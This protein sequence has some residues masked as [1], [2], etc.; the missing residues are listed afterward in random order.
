MRPQGGQ[1][2]SVGGFMSGARVAA[3]NSTLNAW[4]GRRQKSWMTSQPGA[5]PSTSTCQHE[6]SGRLGRPPSRSQHPPPQDTTNPTPSTHDNVSP[7]TARPPNTTQPDPEFLP[8]SEL[9][10][11]TLDSAAALPSPAPTDQPS[12]PTPASNQLQ[13][14]TRDQ[15]RQ[16]PGFVLRP[17]NIAAGV[18]EFF[19]QQAAANRPPEIL[20]GG[21]A[22][23]GQEASNTDDYS[24]SMFA[25]NES[26]VRDVE[27]ALS[28]ASPSLQNRS[29]TQIPAL[30]SPGIQERRPSAAS[31][32][33]PQTYPGQPSNPAVQN[34]S[35]ASS[36]TQQPVPQQVVS[37]HAVSQ[38]AAPPLP[39][40]AQNIN[41]AGIANCLRPDA[42]S[43]QLEKIVQTCVGQANS[44]PDNTTGPRL[45]LLKDAI[46][47]GD[48]FY[49]ALHQLL[50]SW[51]FSREWVIHTLQID[52]SVA[53]GGMK[54]V[55]NTLR[56]NDNMAKEFVFLFANFPD[57]PRSGL[58]N[59]PFYR[60]HIDNVGVFLRCLHSQW[61]RVLIPTMK[62]DNGRG[63]PILATELHYQ[64]RLRSPVLEPVIFTVTRRHMGIADGPVAD[65]MQQLFQT[66]LKTD[67]SRM[68]ESDQ[69]NLRDTLIKRY[70]QLV[71]EYQSQSSPQAPSFMSSAQS[72]PA[73]TAP[74]PMPSN[75]AMTPAMVRQQ[76]MMNNAR[77]LSA[78]Y[79]GTQ[80]TAP[81]LNAPEGFD[82]YPS[83]AAPGNFSPIPPQ[84]TLHN[85]G[86]VAQVRGLQMPM[87]QNIARAPSTGS[88]LSQPLTPAGSPL[89]ANTQ[90]P[91]TGRVVQTRGQTSPVLQAPPSGL[92]VSMPTVSSP[93]QMTSGPHSPAVNTHSGFLP[94]NGYQGPR[95]PYQQ[96]MQQ[97]MQAQQ[98]QAQQMQAQQMQVQQ[99][100]AQQLQAQQMRQANRF[101]YQLPSQVMGSASPPNM[102]TPQFHQIPQPWPPQGATQQ[103]PP[104]PLQGATHQITPRPVHSESTGL[105]SP[106]P[107]SIRGRAPAPRPKGAIFRPPHQHVPLDQIPHTPHEPKALANSLH[108]VDVRSPRRVPRELPMKDDPMPPQRHYQSVKSLA[109][110]PVATTPRW[111]LHKFDFMV[112]DGV[113][114][115]LCTDRF[116]IGQ[117]I[118]VSQYFNGSL[119][120]R[121]RLCA[122][123]LKQGQETVPEA[124][125]AVA[126][127]YWPDHISV[128]VNKKVMKIR[129]KQHNGQDQPVEL[130]RHLC[131]GSNAISVSIAPQACARKA[132][133][134]TYFMAVEVVET[135]NHQSIFN[136]V[137]LRGVIPV[138]STRKLIQDRLKPPQNDGDDELAVVGSDLS[139][140]LADPFSSTIYE[141][142]VRGAACTHLECF[143][144]GNWLNSRPSKPMCTSHGNSCNRP[145]GGGELGPEPSLVDRWKCPVCDGDAR[146]YSLMMDSFMAEVR[147]KLEADRKLHTKTIFVAADGTWRPKV[148]E[149]GDDEGD[150]AEGVPGRP[151]AK[152]ART[153]PSPAEAPAIEIIELD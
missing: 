79:P 35:P 110:G 77:R 97:Q 135:L 60:Q 117:Q 38:Q 3:S 102:A 29:A 63:Y 5:S 6:K 8:T 4:M 68:S 71:R 91:N 86:R 22:P 92:S 55:Q 108:Q 13:Q 73:L 125:W 109:L 124:A 19:A 18:A 131:R 34:S 30:Q 31:M 144:L 121:L 17:S 26:D 64:L 81:N 118:P 52:P 12:P 66:D 128:V 89:H 21:G 88:Q 141:I 100:Q 104:R 76:Q 43:L 85:Q 152:R 133:D 83:P 65:K 145:C 14:Q 74:T 134:T 69:S 11:Q 1:Q 147:K 93:T 129:R 114:D 23:S 50:C 130:T 82:M 101:N 57:S 24:G 103:L 96:T 48:Y 107:S 84:Y 67:Y 132:A 80:L 150:D 122:I 127:T 95:V 111:E 39:P 53:D 40:A 59:L 75:V 27:V 140:D 16:S 44:T 149:A 72:M 120:Y 61:N 49:I 99:M 138:D 142:P 143:D 41:Q 146:P 62:P 25:L 119:R 136:M 78:G 58:W 148:E 42:M 87:P 51:S 37:Q 7:Q 32:P 33:E 54:V 45:K 90:L 115:R 10:K 70:K 113:F 47:V 105:P 106:I 56:R 112:P 151:P 137:T 28:G 20:G 126:P 116:P 36:V 46:E 139:I 98:L 2:D 123:R 94:P 9:G 15:D 153:G